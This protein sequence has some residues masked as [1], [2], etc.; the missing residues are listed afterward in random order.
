MRV[1]R[2]AVRTLKGGAA[3]VLV[4]YPALTV[5]RTFASTDRA[6]AYV[7]GKRFR[8]LPLYINGY[9]SVLP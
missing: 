9:P 7:Q 4:G 5:R 8:G 6:L 2:L 3:D 1:K